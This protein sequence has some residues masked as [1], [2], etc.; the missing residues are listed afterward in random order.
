[1]TAEY[2]G[3]Q[4]SGII[5][6]TYKDRVTIWAGATRSSLKGLYPVDLLQWRIIEFANRNGFKYCEILGANMP[7]ISY[8]K[9]RYNF[10]LDIYYYVKK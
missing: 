2:E 6:F 10:D 1:M 3:E 8:F 5:F 7:T 4:A 9:S